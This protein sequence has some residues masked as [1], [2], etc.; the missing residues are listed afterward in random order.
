VCGVQCKKE[1]EQKCMLQ[2]SPYI[3]M[4]ACM[5]VCV[6]VYVCVCVCVCMCV[7][8]SVCVC[9]C[10]WCYF[11]WRTNWVLIVADAKNKGLETTK[12]VKAPFPCSV[13]A[14][15][16]TLTGQGLKKQHD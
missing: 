9:M 4:H 8:V 14:E 1:D 5:C 10:V 12:V 11:E 6:C 13:V 15:V 16:Q 3:F 2:A 7:F